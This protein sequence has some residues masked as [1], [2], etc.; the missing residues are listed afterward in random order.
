MRC[1]DDDIIVC[2]H[3]AK[4]D[5]GIAMSMSSLSGSW[6]AGSF[7]TFRAGRNA[8]LSPKFLK[9]IAAGPPPS[10]VSLE[11]CRLFMATSFC[12]TF[13]D[14]HH[15]KA[16]SIMIL[17]NP[18]GV[19]WLKF[20]KTASRIAPSSTKNTGNTVPLMPSMGVSI[21]LPLQ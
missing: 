10:L 14:I 17:S 6:Q 12:L 2:L 18:E 15:N 11:K 8:N 20:S 16:F 5:L 3:H 4:L 19:G 1:Q 21:F 9:I 13:D 7:E